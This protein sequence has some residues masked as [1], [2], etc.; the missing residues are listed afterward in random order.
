LAD[1]K[2]VQGRTVLHDQILNVI[3]FAMEVGKSILMHAKGDSCRIVAVGIVAGITAVDAG[4]GY[5]IHKGGQKL[6]RYLV[7]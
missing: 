2:V 4:V 6:Y 5:G 7:D 3:D 1:I